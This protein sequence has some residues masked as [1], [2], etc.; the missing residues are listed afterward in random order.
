M[1]QWKTTLPCNLSGVAVHGRVTIW[2][3]L[4][5]LQQLG[6][7]WMGRFTNCTDCSRASCLDIRAQVEIIFFYVLMNNKL[8]PCVQA[9]QT[10]V[11]PTMAVVPIFAWWRPWSRRARPLTPASA[12]MERTSSQTCTPVKEPSPTPRPRRHSNQPRCL[13]SSQPPWATT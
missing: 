5:Q 1:Y 2:G 13:L 10:A 3:H 12:P 9:H 8:L 7:V 4:Q 11:E 6:V